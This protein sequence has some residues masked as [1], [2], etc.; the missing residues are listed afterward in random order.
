MRQEWFPPIILPIVAPAERQRFDPLIEDLGYRLELC[1]AEFHA[2]QSEL[3]LQT[4]DDRSV[5]LAD[6]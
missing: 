5:H 1:R 4:V 2:T 6:T 3:C